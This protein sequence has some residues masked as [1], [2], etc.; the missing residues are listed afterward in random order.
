MSN[1]IDFVFEKFT[2]KILQKLEDALVAKE[3][4][5]DVRLPWQKPYNEAQTPQNP[6]TK[7]V[8]TGMNALLLSMSDFN[9]PFW[10]TEK[11]I[12]DIKGWI[13][14]GAKA[15]YIVFWKMLNR[16]VVNEEGETSN[17]V[18]PLLRYT[19]VF[20][21]EQLESYD[22]TKLKLPDYNALEFNPLEQAEALVEAYKDKPVIL[23]NRTSTPCYRPKSDEIVMPAKDQFKS[24]EDYYATLFH[25]LGH[26]TGASTRL[27]REGITCFDKFGSHR[28]S[29]EELIAEFTAANL[30]GMCNID[31]VQVDNSV[32]YIS[33]WSKRFKEDKNIIVKAASEAHKA[34]Q[35]IIK[36]LEKTNSESEENLAC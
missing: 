23:T 15:E 20:N 1:K 30:C 28:Y 34:T 18:Y 12:K 25:E 16:S 9:S 7:N 27:N 21:L 33:S 8:Y 4:G 32:A 13:K 3:K 10:L 14:K 17:K 24:I 11:N 31:N 2:D 5:E 35:Y 19:R 6:I 29:I 22:E 26:S 36:G